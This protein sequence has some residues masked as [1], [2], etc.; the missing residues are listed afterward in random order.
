MFNR[1]LQVK[2]VKND[3]AV[4]ASP[5]RPDHNFEGKVAIIGSHLGKCVDKA[6]RALIAYVVV[7]T[8]RQ[9]LITKANRPT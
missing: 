2:M 5:N 8:I 3:K 4:A 6:G 1:A 7:D 9:V